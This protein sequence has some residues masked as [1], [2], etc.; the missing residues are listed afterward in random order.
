MFQIIGSILILF[1]MIFIFSGVIGFF[2]LPGFYTKLHV[3]GLIECC[4]IPLCLIGL[5][6]LN[7][8]TTGSF[9]LCFA[10]LLVLLLSPV[11][12]HALGKAA[13]LSPHLSNIDSDDIK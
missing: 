10:A 2:R 6:C 9:K 4:G 8:S 11:S 12:T 7:H 1:G 5:A 3:A 13:I